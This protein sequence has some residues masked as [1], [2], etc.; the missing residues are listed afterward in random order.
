MSFV[1]LAP[2]L[3]LG[4][5]TFE[6]LADYPLPVWPAAL[7]VAVWWSRESPGRP[8]VDAALRQRDGR[9]SSP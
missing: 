1:L 5:G 2:A 6:R 4:W 3:H 9:R 8:S 7:G